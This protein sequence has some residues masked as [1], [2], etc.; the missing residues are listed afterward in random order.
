MADPQFAHI[1]NIYS[2]APGSAAALTQEV[3]LQALRIARDFAAKKLEID[4]FAAVFA[5]DLLLVP[6]FFCQS[7]LLSRSILDCAKH[8]NGRR[9]PLLADILAGLSRVSKADYYIFSNIDISPL[10]YFYVSLAQIAAQGYDAFIVTRRTIHTPYHSCHDLPLM[11]ADLGQEHPGCDCFIFKR[12]LF[13]KFQLGRVAV[14]SEFVALA[15]R[16]NL[17]A[18]A[19]KMKIFRDLHLTFHLGDERAWL[20]CAADACFNEK[21]V[22]EIFKHLFAERKL[23]RREELCALHAG[24]LQR[25][26]RLRS[27]KENPGRN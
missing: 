12:E 6:D 19:R 27:R 24:Y 15:L 5:D 3:T 11:Y 26:Q 9:L 4:L 25:K 10:P 18:H 23:P 7:T 2:A 21:E 1:V 16:A 22:D 17:T 8:H 14:G 20:K 13:G